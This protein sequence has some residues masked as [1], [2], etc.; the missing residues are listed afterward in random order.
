METEKPLVDKDY[1]LFKTEGKG[2]W[3]F[4]EIPEIPMPKA[5]FGMLKVKG[6]IDNYE[7]S[8]VHLMP[9]GNGHLGLAVKSEIR[10]KI[11][12]EAPDT[13]HIILYEDKTPLIIPEELLL[14]MEYEDGVLEKFETYSDGQKKAFI[15]W[16]NSAKTEQTK[17]DRI[18][19]TIVMIQNNEKF[20]DKI[21]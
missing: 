1:S 3:T 5:S 12:K 9:L 21:K 11:K 2:G 19:K 6:K 7:F 8:N 13:V 20:Y 4:A 14:C 15:D 17:V 16:I 10:K 18:A